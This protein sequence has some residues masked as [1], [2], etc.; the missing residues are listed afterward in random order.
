MIY[1]PVRRTSLP[2]RHTVWLCR[3][4]Q[5]TIAPGRGKGGGW[6]CARQRTQAVTKGVTVLTNLVGPHRKSR[7]AAVRDPATNAREPPGH[8]GQTTARR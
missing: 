1:R 6:P 2:I 4:R 7:V 5:A 8:G 3:Y